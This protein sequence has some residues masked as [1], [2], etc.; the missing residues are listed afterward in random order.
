[1]RC[2]VIV[3]TYESPRALHLCLVALYAQYRDDFNVCIADDGSSSETKELIEQ[4]LPRFGMSSLRHLWQPHN[5]F[6]KNKILNKAISESKADYLIFI[7]GDCVPSPKFIERHISLAQPSRFLT[8]GVIR[9]PESVSLLLQEANVAS[10]EVFNPTWLS[11]VGALRRL[12][13]RIK[14]G[15]FPHRLT[16]FIEYITPVKRTWNGGNSSGW[17]Q[18]LLTINGF[19]ESLS[20]GAEDI[21]LGFRLNNIGVA[22]RHLRYSA[23]LLHLEHARQYKDSVQFAA[24][25]KHVLR[26]RGLSLKWTNQGILKGHP[27]AFKD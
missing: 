11:S 8:G 13:D 9:L 23:P 16:N 5:G 19:D 25:R 24:N 2:E 10:G 14:L 17:R 27:N 22:G 26:L 15:Q 6:G 4:W 18:D 1:M 3:S 21:E 20:Y 12:S 7:D